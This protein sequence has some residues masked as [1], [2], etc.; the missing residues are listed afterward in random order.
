M[1]TLEENEL[2]TK[3]GPGTPT[4]DLFR[5]YWHPIAATL[6]LD[7]NPTKEVRILGEDLVLYKDR[8]GKHGLIGR[9]CAHRRVN[10][11]YG[12]PEENGLRCMYHGWMYDETGQCI[13]QPFEE[14]VRPESRFKDKIK[15][16]GY[17]VQDY[18]GLLWTYMGPDPA[19]LLPRWEPFEWDNTVADI[20]VAVLN[21]NWLQCQENS[22]D[23]VHLEWLHGYWGQ[24]QT[25]MRREKL[26]KDI[27][28][29]QLIPRHH[30][31]IGFTIFDHG[32]VKRRV[33]EGG[34]EE[35]ID[36]TVGH[37]ALFPNILFVGD[38]IKANL[39]YRVPIDDENTLHITFFAYRAA[40]GKEIPAQDEIP[41]FKVPLQYEDG[42]LIA[43][44]TNHQD[45]VAWITQG[46][47]VD[48]GLE[49]LGESDRGIIL[50]RKL[51]KEQLQI[52]ADG[53]DPMN[54]FRDPERN[55]SIEL[56]LERWPALQQ[57]ERYQEYVALQAGEDP[58]FG[59]EVEVA[60]ATWTG[61]NPADLK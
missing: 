38:A 15:L 46:P 9:L 56:P 3:V 18:R 24:H 16:P 10:L 55:V 40:P 58:N 7:E 57:L 37:P 48:R 6:E 23:P 20:G 51:L 30:Q 52:V 32:V 59:E 2:L 50:W 14:T 4:G 28:Y 42:P 29:V 36:W 8:S 1:L 11:A 33:V 5:R 45:F 19:P 13:E 41:Y 17:P 61:V 39:Q 43:D 25:M 22:L 44:L 35:D 27:S 26:G 34:S 53:G 12:I 49:R 47:V 21:C 54:V 60:M 31:K